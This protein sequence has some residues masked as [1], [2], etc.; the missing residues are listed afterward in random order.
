MRERGTV[1]K[2]IWF[3]EVPENFGVTKMVFFGT[4]RSRNIY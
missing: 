3:V 4:L 2:M 1:M